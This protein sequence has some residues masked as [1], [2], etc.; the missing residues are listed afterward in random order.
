MFR[1][2]SASLVLQGIA[3]LRTITRAHVI[4]WRKVLEKRW[5]AL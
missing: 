2:E 3:G 4:T 5:L 1:S